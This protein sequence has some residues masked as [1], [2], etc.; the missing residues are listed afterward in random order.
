M[1]WLYWERDESSGYTGRINKNRLVILGQGKKMSSYTGR[2][3]ELVVLL[4]A[5]NCVSQ[6]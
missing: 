4:V 3:N 5:I 2:V 6:I 1:N